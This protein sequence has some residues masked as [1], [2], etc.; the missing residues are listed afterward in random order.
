MVFME[1]AGKTLLW[2]GLSEINNWLN[3]TWEYDGADW[4]QV[5]DTGP[6][7]EFVGIAYDSDREVTVL[8]SRRLQVAETWEWDG[9][10]WTQIG[11]TGP[12]PLSGYYRMAYDRARKVTILEGG[13]QQPGPL[14]S[15]AV[16]TW[17]W[18]GTAW[19]QLADVGPVIR[20][21]AGL[22]Y[23]EPREQV[24]FFGGWTVGVEQGDTWAWDGTDWKQVADIGPSPRGGHAMAGTGTAVLLFGGL[25]SAP[26]YLADTWEWD[27]KHWVQRQDMGPSGR[28]L[29]G[30]SWDAARARAVLFGGES[31]TDKTHR[32]TWESFEG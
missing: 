30:I 20:Y 27:G 19:T 24:V 23:D 8:F 16:G 31:G 32:D 4:V 11:D 2:G 28:C 13:G 25:A 14:S 10:V 12:Q 5:A 29:A 22:A 17:A 21:D 15:S 1:S 6:S 26:T 9:E 18:D 7:P 3:D